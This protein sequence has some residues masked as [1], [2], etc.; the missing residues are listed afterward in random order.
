MTIRWNGT[1][2][3]GIPTLIYH[4][5]LITSIDNLITDPNGAGSLICS[6]VNETVLYWITTNNF[7]ALRPAYTS[8]YF[9]QTRE[10]RG[11]APPSLTQLSLCL[12]LPDPPLMSSDLNGLW[13]C[14]DFAIP[15]ENL[16]PHVGVYSR[17]P[18]KRMDD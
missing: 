7:N 16:G 3:T 13:S 5:E 14:R 18:G 17:A 9:K 6:S 15:G 2:I 10:H 1:D 8:G 12:P 4:D 11:S